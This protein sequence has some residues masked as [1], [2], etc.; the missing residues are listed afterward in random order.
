M[1]IRFD[2]VL[3]QFELSEHRSAS[4]GLANYRLLDPSRPWF[5]LGVDGK[6][7]IM[8]IKSSS[9]STDWDQKVGLLSIRH[10]SIDAI[11]EGWGEGAF[12]IRCDSL[13]RAR[14]APFVA[15]LCTRVDPDEPVDSTLQIIDEWSDL[16]NRIRGPLSLEAQRGL[17]GELLCFRSMIESIGNDSI[18]YWTGPTRSPQDFI[19]ETWRV[20]VKTIG[21]KIA[22]PKISS[23][24]Q[25][26]PSDDYSLHLILISIKNGIEFSLNDLVEEIRAMLADND[27]LENLLY[28]AGYYTKHIDHYTR[29]YDFVEATY[30]EITAESNV[31]HKNMLT[32]DI[33]A[34]DRLQWVLRSEELPFTRLPDDFWSTL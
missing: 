7:D 33:P 24:E 20:E 15:D 31:L 14:I 25:L 4:T 10:G 19:A 12:L 8:A 11:I 34:I 21:T 23:L 32:Q 9:K 30:C 27:E 29:K 5:L 28:Q 17:I 1:T 18:R 22:R 13:E 2:R 26:L 6:W 3:S 16:W